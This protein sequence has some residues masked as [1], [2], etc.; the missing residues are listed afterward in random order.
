MQYRSLVILYDRIHFFPDEL[1]VI[2]AVESY[3]RVMDTNEL[4]TTK[5]YTVTVGNPHE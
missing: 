4:C 5:N 2:F 3:T 1:S